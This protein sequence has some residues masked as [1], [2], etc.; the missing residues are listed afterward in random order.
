MLNGVVTGGTGRSAAL[1]GHPAA[2]KTGTTQDYHDAWFVGFTADYVAGVWVG[3]DDSSPMKNVT[4][5]SLPAEIWEGVMGF[6]ENPLPSRPLDMSDPTPPA[7][8][9][10]DTVLMGGS[11]VTTGDDEN[12]NGGGGSTSVTG[13]VGDDEAPVSRGQPQQEQRGGFL[14]WLF[15]RSH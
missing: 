2:G 6:A 3:N 12:A 9:E 15:G 5:G 10:T 8:D 14:D 4:G 1:S 11:G 7:T 13:A